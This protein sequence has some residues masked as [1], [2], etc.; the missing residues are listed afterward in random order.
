MRGYSRRI[1]LLEHE[2][3]DIINIQFLKAIVLLRS[4]LLLVGEVAGILAK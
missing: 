1:Y 2:K 4:S 3:R